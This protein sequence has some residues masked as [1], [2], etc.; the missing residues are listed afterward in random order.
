MTMRVLDYYGGE[1][2]SEGVNS[3]KMKASPAEGAT[4]MMKVT[5]HFIA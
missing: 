3:P 4:I 1:K 5:S 2:H